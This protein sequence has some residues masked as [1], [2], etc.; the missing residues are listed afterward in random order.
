MHRLRS[1]AVPAVASLAAILVIASPAGAAPNGVWRIVPS[2]SPSD[3]G[4]YL[5]S[6]A[7]LAPDDVWAVGAWYRPIATPGTLT[8]HWDGSSWTDHL[9]VVETPVQTG[10]VQTAP[11]QVA[12]AQAAPAQVVIEPVPTHPPVFEQVAPAAP[13]MV[14]TCCV[15]YQ[16]PAGTIV[17][18]A[19]C[20]TTALGAWAATLI[21]PFVGNM[22]F[23]AY[24][25]I[26]AVQMGLRAW[27]GRARPATG[28][29][30][31]GE[32]AR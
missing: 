20:T 21:D 4:N 32:P 11:P 16:P 24:L 7:A 28:P 14:T 12:P 2:Q 30:E 15:A 13:L 10:P 18:V 5:T 31:P 8:E 6:V 1:T 23:A 3:Q 19:A 17:G 26:I 25:V 29:A 27:R 9:L 22:L